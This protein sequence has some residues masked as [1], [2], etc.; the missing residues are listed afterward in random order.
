MIL[1]ISNNHHGCGTVIHQVTLPKSRIIQAL[2]YRE[3]LN[4]GVLQKWLNAMDN[5]ELIVV[6]DTWVELLTH[7]IEDM[8]LNYL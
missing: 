6:K 3:N 1:F 8:V 5:I 4:K 7:H 2:E